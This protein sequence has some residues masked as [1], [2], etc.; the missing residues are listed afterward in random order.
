[1]EAGSEED[2]L[3]RTANAVVAEPDYRS[4]V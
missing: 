1:V 3:V 4:P 2:R